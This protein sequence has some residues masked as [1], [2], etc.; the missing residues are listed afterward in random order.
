MYFRNTV[1]SDSSKL[2]TASLVLIYHDS[3]RF[4]YLLEALESVSSQQSPF[5][6]IILVDS[7]ESES[8]ILAIFKSFP[9]L[10]L[11]HVKTDAQ[12]PAS[13]RNLGFDKAKGDIVC[14]LDDD[15]IMLPRHSKLVLQA[16]MQDPECDFVFSSKIDFCDRRVIS[17][18]KMV[19]PNYQNIIKGN[20]ADTSTIAIRKSSKYISRWDSA[21]FHEDWAF[22][23]DAFMAGCKITPLFERTILYRIHSGARRNS[24]KRISSQM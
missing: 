6:E 14:F 24:I 7:S 11:R 21:V 16:F 13:K 12:H 9:S 20:I 4:P 2:M 17:I 3:N 10:G 18:P 1:K 19:K 8:D 22:L 15:N 23:I 5:S